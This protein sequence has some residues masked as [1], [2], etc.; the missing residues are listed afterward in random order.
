[1][2]ASWVRIS[3]QDWRGR[4][5]GW[6]PDHGV[7]AWVVQRDVADPALY[8]GT[9]M[10]DAGLDPRDPAHAALAEAWLE[11]FDSAGVEGVG[12]GFVYL[13]RTDQPTSLVAED[14]RHGFDDPLGTEAL[15]HFARTAWLRGADVTQARFRFDPATALERVYLPAD[16]G[17]GPDAG[18]WREVVTR[19]HR[20]GGPRWQHE[21][22]AGSL[23]L[24][25]GLGRGELTTAQVADL[26]AAAR[27]ADPAA[28]TEEAAALVTALVRHGLLR[29]VTGNT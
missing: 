25:T 9:W 22:D 18:T 26:L 21:L 13:Q 27:G 29:A 7:E 16:G 20:G 28:L 23:Q 19:L 24:L 11:H 15:D 4:I 6:L 8:V 17:A 14:L 2:L 10:R 5:A 1:M 3:G 12:F